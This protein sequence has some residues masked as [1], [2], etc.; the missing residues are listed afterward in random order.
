MAANIVLPPLTSWAQSHLTA[1]FQ[2]TDES[3][4]SDAFDAF[5]A[6][7]PTS[8]VVNGKRLSR[9]AYKAQVWKDKFLE[10]GAEVRFLGTNSVTSNPEQPVTVRASPQC[11]L[12]DVLTLST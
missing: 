8:I 12:Y 9:D 7:Q 5:I 11:C 1:I 10:A 3:T 4:F 6:A 2:A